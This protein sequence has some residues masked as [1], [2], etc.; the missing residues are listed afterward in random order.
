MGVDISN[1]VIKHERSISN[2]KGKKIAIDAY[3]SLYQFLASIRQP[4]GTPLKDFNGNIT[5]HLSGIFYRTINLMENG[6]T[7]VYV[8]DGKPPE[9]KLRELKKRTEKKEEY[10]L[11]AEK[12]RDREEE[13]LVKR[14]MQAVL[15]LTKN[16]V[17][18]TKELLDA[19]GVFYVNS[20]SEGE[21][22][23]SYMCRTGKVYASSS[24][25]YDSLLFGSK[26]LIRNLS[27]TGRRKLPRRDQ[28]VMIFPEEIFLQEVLDNLS[29]TREKLIIIGILV[30]TDFNKGVRGIGPKKALA[31][32]K[33]YDSFEKIRE[34]V[35]KSYNHEFEE[36]IEDV[37]NFFLNPPAVDVEIEEK[38]INED[39]IKEILIERHDFGRE[40]VENAIAKLKKATRE[41]R[42]GSITDW[43]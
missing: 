6:I 42:Q 1:I 11:L 5:S 14:Y 35:E 21:A 27:I 3:N 37:Y 33:K 8:F 41:I 30:G 12:A 38:K 7:P 29:I 2:F 31:L 17:E 9:F 24:Q 13:D 15:R 16:Q 28:Y 25:D 18:E 26:V 39:K 20:P 4:D 10:A 36:Y 22:Q 40:R 43:F 34:E 23:A 32:V 19:M